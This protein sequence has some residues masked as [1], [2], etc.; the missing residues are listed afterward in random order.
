LPR[1]ACSV[2]V[3]PSGSVSS[4]NGAVCWAPNSASCRRNR[5]S[6]Q[7]GT[8]IGV[9]THVVQYSQEDCGGCSSPRWRRSR[10]CRERVRHVRRSAPRPRRRMCSPGRLVLAAAPADRGLKNDR[11]KDREWSQS[12]RA[13]G[14]TGRSLLHTRRQGRP[15]SSAESVRCERRPRAPFYAIAPVRFVRK[16][17]LGGER[18]G[19]REAIRSASTCAGPSRPSALREPDTRAGA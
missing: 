11:R 19:S 12:E 14:R 15:T 5:V 7:K 13:R 2:I 4:T 9:A 1:G 18:S 3:S 6:M 8:W 16:L 10:R 17:T